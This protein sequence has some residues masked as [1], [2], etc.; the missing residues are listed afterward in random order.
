MSKQLCNLFFCFLFS[1][2]TFND[3][4]VIICMLMLTMIGLVR[5]AFQM[6]QPI[7]LKFVRSYPIYVLL[8]WLYD[9]EI[10]IGFVFYDLEKEIGGGKFTFDRFSLLFSSKIFVFFFKKKIK[11]VRLN[12]SI[13]WSNNKDMIMLITFV[14]HKK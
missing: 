7:L 10:K 12:F 2:S 9:L 3:S 1:P 8:I 4:V 13:E 5:F 14:H 6:G 11:G